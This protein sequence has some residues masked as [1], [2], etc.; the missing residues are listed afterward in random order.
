MSELNSPNLQYVINQ[1]ALMHPTDSL[2]I[3]PSIPNHTSNR[4]F[5]T[6]MGINRAPDMDRAVMPKETACIAV[7]GSCRSKVCFSQCS[8]EKYKPTP[9][10][11]LVIDYK[12]T[13]ITNHLKSIHTQ[14]IIINIQ[15]IQ[16]I[17]SPA[18]CLSKVRRH[19]LSGQ[20]A[21]PC[22]ASHFSTIYS[23]QNIRRRLIKRN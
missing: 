14:L 7:R 16:N 10:T 5:T 3:F 12:S 17:I 4:V 13:F 18:S 1:C 6:V 8:D 15:N 23:K 22:P 20:C 19:S 9:G 21:I 2:Y 11:T